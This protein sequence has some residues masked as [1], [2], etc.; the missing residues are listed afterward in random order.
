MKSTRW[1][2]R[3]RPSP[4]GHVHFL[5][6]PGLFATLAGCLLMERN[7]ILSGQKGA[8][9]DA[10]QV[11]GDWMHVGRRATVFFPDCAYCGIFL[12]PP[13]LHLEL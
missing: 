12:Q 1:E 6:W 9:R 13:F 5:E 3:W 8:L 4:W 10:R 11:G 7:L 2:H